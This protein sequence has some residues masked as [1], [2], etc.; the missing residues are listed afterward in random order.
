V[1]RPRRTP[2]PSPGFQP[3]A[4]P[5][6]RAPA[7]ASPGTATAGKREDVTLC[8]WAAEKGKATGPLGH[9]RWLGRL[10]RQACRAR[11]PVFE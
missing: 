3:E 9:P 6:M 10:S 5:P 2:A 1:V 7:R 4:P 11:R 8:S